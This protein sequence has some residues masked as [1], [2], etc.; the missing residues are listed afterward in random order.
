M[1]AISQQLMDVY[2]IFPSKHKDFCFHIALKTCIFHENIMKEK[3]RISWW[4]IYTKSTLTICNL[5]ITSMLWL[6]ILLHIWNGKFKA[7]LLHPWKITVIIANVS[8]W[9]K[10]KKAN[11]NT[12]SQHSFQCFTTLSMT[13]QNFWNVHEKV[14]D[15]FF[16]EK[17]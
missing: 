13:N 12:L 11:C 3:N 2:N 16:L 17:G 4:L 6:A 14:F 1:L 7:F 9:V 8:K 5:L 10:I 15:I